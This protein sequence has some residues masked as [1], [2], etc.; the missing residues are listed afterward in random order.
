MG[1]F[2]KMQFIFMIV[3]DKKIMT[4][5]GRRRVESFWVIG[6]TLTKISFGNLV[7]CVLINSLLISVQLLH[8]K[9]YSVLQFLYWVSFLLNSQPVY[10]N[11][12]GLTQN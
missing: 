9:S 2:K 10:C 6:E 3:F 12:T 1:G 4:L 7:L 5:S 8:C 11:L